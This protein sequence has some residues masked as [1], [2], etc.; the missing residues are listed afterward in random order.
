MEASNNLKPIIS[1]IVPAMLGYHS[2]LAALNSWEAQRCRDQLEILVLC[3]TRL[4]IRYRQAML[5][6]KLDQ[7]CFTR[8]GPPESEE[9]KRDWGSLRGSLSTGSGMR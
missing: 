2:I 3:P 5:L 7:C 8:R 6:W 4:I 9:R 1:I